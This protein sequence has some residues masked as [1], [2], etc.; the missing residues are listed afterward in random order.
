VTVL[1]NGTELLDILLN[2]DD[3]EP[4]FARVAAVHWPAELRV[5][6][7]QTPESRFAY[8][9]VRVRFLAMGVGGNP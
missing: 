5:I 8:L 2:D 6:G 4:V 9:P 7:R 3:G 1:I